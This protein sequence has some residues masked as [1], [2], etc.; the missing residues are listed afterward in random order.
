MVLSGQLVWQRGTIMT[1][2][3]EVLVMDKNLYKLNGTGSSMGS[4]GSTGSGIRSSTVDFL[5]MPLIFW[6]SQGIKFMA[7]GQLPGQE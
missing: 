6:Q 4:G 7:R 2:I 5:C 1:N 3:K